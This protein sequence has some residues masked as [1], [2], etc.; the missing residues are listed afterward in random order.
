MPNVEIFSHK[1][2][3]SGL[4]K[5]RLIPPQLSERKKGGRPG[6]S[7]AEGN[8]LGRKEIFSGITIVCFPA[9]NLPKKKKEELWQGHPKVPKPV[10]YPIGPENTLLFGEWKTRCLPTGCV[11][12]K[13]QLSAPRERQSSC[14][15]EGER[16]G[17]YNW[18]LRRRTL[19]RGK[20]TGGRET[21]ELWGPFFWEYERVKKCPYFVWGLGS[22][23]EGKEI[24]ETVRSGSAGI[25]IVVSGEEKKKETSGD[26]SV[27]G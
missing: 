3:E 20:K 15:A 23:P 17:G 10:R 12:T 21:F 6:P 1:E 2:G 13:G 5:G 11:R 19:E 7:A 25:S 24:W 4:D 18:S 8:D 22:N 14:T 9:R 26:F 16:G 27:W